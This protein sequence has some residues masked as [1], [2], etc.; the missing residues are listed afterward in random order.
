VRI[1]QD[2]D[3]VLAERFPEESLAMRWAKVYGER[4]KQQGWV[5]RPELQV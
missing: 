1:L 4:L 2:R 3:L 5:E